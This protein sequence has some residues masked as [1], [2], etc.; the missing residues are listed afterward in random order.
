MSDNEVENV[1]INQGQDEELASLYENPGDSSDE[2]AFSA[3][4]KVNGVIKFSNK[5]DMAFY[6]AG[7]KRFFEDYSVDPT[8]HERP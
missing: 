8:F 7:S 1:D 5:V 6:K 4:P 2:E 3:R